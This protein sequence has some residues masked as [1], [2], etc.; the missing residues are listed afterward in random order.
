MGCP[1]ACMFN[2]PNGSGFLP[3]SVSQLCTT[4]H[5]EFEG[6]F[7]GLTAHSCFHQTILDLLLYS[8]SKT[9]YIINKS[10]GPDKA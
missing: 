8:Y 2:G 5:M 1:M 6:H 4:L 9:S 10:V 3:I 7:M